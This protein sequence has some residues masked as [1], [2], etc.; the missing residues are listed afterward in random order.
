MEVGQ[1]DEK[2]KKEGQEI[3]MFALSLPLQVLTAVQTII[4]SSFL[5]CQKHIDNI[6]NLEQPTTK[7]TGWPENI[8]TKYGL[9]A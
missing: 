3:Y 6:I 9:K 4:G 5:N 7:F 1:R 8:H 2:E